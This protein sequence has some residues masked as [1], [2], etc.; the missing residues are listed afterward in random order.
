MGGAACRRRRSA[1]GDRR[2]TDILA[3][4][5]VDEALLAE[6]YDLEHDEIA[7]DL[8][9]YREWARRAGDGVVDL[10]C[11]SGR[12]F[13][14]LWRG[15]ARR[16]VGIDGSPALLDRARARIGADDGLRAAHEAG[17]IELLVGDV[18]T[19]RHRHRFALA[20]LAGVLAHLDGPEDAV[21]A[22]AAAGRL[23]RRDG[24]LIVDLLGP[25]ALPPHDLPLSVDWERPMGDRRVVR[26]SRLLRHEA[27]EGLRVDY[28]TLTDLG[29]AGGT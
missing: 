1:Q 24:V 20:I 10:G 23:L 11:G 27:P 12:L 14:T 18:R 4:Q 15:G 22:L 3:G 26:R 5:P 25:G 8:G 28:S 21:R 13:G 2:L 9:F 16:I 7:E 17:R 19:V 29:E 6:L